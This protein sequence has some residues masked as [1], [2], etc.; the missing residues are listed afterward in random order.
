MADRR[1]RDDNPASGVRG[2][3]GLARIVIRRVAL[4]LKI[5]D[6]SAELSDIVAEPAIRTATLVPWRQS[7]PG[8]HETEIVQCTMID[9]AIDQGISWR[10]LFGGPDDLIGRGARYGMKNAIVCS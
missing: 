4:L 2:F 8:Y 9:G 6:R 5:A 3:H 10:R 7:W 1:A